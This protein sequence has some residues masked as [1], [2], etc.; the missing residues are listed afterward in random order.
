MSLTS[1]LR[2]G[3]LA[4][5]CATHLPGTA[6]ITH[7]VRAAAAAR[8][9]ARV[10]GPGGAGHA[11]AVG[12]IVDARLAALV[13][14]A[15]P[16]AALN[17]YLAAGLCSPA[18]A[19]RIAA[20]YPSV[21]S[22]LEQQPELADTA[23]G[24]RPTPSDVL[25][26]TSPAPAAPDPRWGDAALAELAE[27]G[28]RFHHTHAPTGTIGG[29]GAETALARAYHAWALGEDRYRGGATPPAL[30]DLAASTTAPTVEQLRGLC[31]PAVA[32]DA[33]AIAS[34]LGESGALARWRHWAGD[35]A[36]GAGLGYASPLLVPHW[37]EADLLIDD[38]LVEVKTVARVD[39]P[40]RIARWC[41]QLLGY[42]WLDVGDRW[43]IRRVALY[44]ARH[45]ITLEWPVPELETVLVGDPGQIEQ[46]RAAFR[47][48][49][50]QS[51]I[52]EGAT[53]LPPP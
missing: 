8:A 5:W 24:V 34:L 32:A 31:P 17:G 45:G 51:A 4:R 25:A 14:D 11:A 48:L 2:A 30:A 20:A 28:H 1:Q 40:A 22:V 36:P 37:A 27:R 47:R 50:G 23:V 19:H 13:H 44:L 6:E 7:Q 33:A 16:Y 10:T 52:A 43:R 9:P 41:W 21:Q 53:L 26:I 42:A 49:A 38:T 39:Q 35:P 29:Y 15:P 18:A 46:T 3:A 12:S